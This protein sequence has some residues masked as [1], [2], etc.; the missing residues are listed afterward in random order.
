[1]RSLRLPGFL[2]NHRR[3][4]S[5]PVNGTS[6]SALTCRTLNANN[7]I[8]RWCPDETDAGRRIGAFQLSAR[9]T[10]PKEQSRIARISMPGK[11]WKNRVPQ[12]R[13]KRIA[14]F[15]RPCGAWL[16]RF[17][18][19]Q[20]APDAGQ[21]RGVQGL[22][23]KHPSVSRRR[24]VLRSST[25]GGGNEFQTSS[26]ASDFLQEAA[27]RRRLLQLFTQALYA[28]SARIT[29]RARLFK[30]PGI[31]LPG[32]LTSTSNHRF[33][34]GLANPAELCQIPAQQ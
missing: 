13:L 17:S 18:K 9:R 21:D 1:M 26:E 27:S 16:F 30:P 11:V 14:V 4:C 24:P 25:A 7:K 6:A 19:N 10:V 31:P 34:R 29:L 23:E 28:A 32:I 2:L 20:D 8:S 15:S 3:G 5:H 12:G 22:C 33:R